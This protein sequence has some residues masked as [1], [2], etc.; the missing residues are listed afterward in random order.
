MNLL[1]FYYFHTAK[2]YYLKFSAIPIF[3]NLKLTLFTM[4][5]LIGFRDMLFIKYEAAFNDSFALIIT[6]SFEVFS[7]KSFNSSKSFF[8]F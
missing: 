4:V 5:D 7:L 1:N 2:V 8:S 3:R 6:I